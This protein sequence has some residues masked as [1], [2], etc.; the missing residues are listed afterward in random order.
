MA[1]TKKRMGGRKGFTLIE[2]LVVI[3]ILGVLAAVAIPAYG[4]FFGSGE[5]EANDT[6]LINVQTA[7]D[8]M[9][10]AGRINGVTAQ[11]TGVDDFGALPAGTGAAALSPT[12][13]RTN[14]TN[15]Q[16]TWTASGTVSQ[17]SGSC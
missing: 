1:T 2:L 11:A 13:L 10:A 4:A 8:A 14:P 12:Y 9:M 6:E 15:C 7:M 17:V 5:D 3:G 16:Y